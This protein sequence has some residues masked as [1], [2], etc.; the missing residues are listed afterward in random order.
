VLPKESRLRRRAQFAEAV[1]QGARAGTPTLVAHLV[2][3]DD[4][5]AARAGFVVSRSVGSAVIRNRVLRQ[6]RHLVRDRLDRLPGGAR[7]VV[8]ATPAAAASSSQR[9]GADL[10][11]ALARLTAAEAKR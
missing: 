4:S 9:L 1:R 10:D 7:L 8:R 5:D 6:L 3:D 2:T 11:R